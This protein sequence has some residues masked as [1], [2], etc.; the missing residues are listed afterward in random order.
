[1][2]PNL[3]VNLLQIFANVGNK[4]KRCYRIIS[5]GQNG[6]RYYACHQNTDQEKSDVFF[7]AHDF[8]PFFANTGFCLAHCCQASSP[9]RK[10]SGDI[11]FNTG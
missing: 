10:Y 5:S 1:M 9:P 7:L 3:V 2:V 4:L 6:R 8:T 11:L